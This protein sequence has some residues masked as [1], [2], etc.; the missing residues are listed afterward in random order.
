MESESESESIRVLIFSVYPEVF[1]A[2]AREQLK[3]RILVFRNSVPE[4]HYEKNEN[5]HFPYPEACYVKMRKLV[6]R[7]LW[8]NVPYGCW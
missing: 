2:I 1:I 6:S 3:T 8:V 5:T 4:A 7:T